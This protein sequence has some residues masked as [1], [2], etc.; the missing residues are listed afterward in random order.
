MS[1]TTKPAAPKGGLAGLLEVLGSRSLR[2]VLVLLGLWAALALHP[3]TRATFLT[4]NNFS[5]LTAQVAE[6]VIIGV[7]M[8]L[9]VLIKGIDLSVGALMAMTGVVAARLQIES[10]QPAVVAVLAAVAVGAL[11]GLWHGFL[12]TRFEI[13]PFIVTLSG[14]MAYRGVGLV[15]SGARGLSPMRDDFGALAALL[16]GPVA[17]GLCLAGAAA[18]VA[19][20]VAGERRRRALGLPTR[21]GSALLFEGAAIAGV[22]AFLLVIYQRGMPV[23]VLIAALTAVLG[24]ALLRRSRM[25][26]YAVAIGGNAEAARLS[27]VPVARVTVGIYLLT[28]VLTAIAAMVATARTN[29]VTPGNAG[30]M[31]EL[32]VISAV[33]IGGTSLNGGRAT[34]VGTI[35]G[36]LIF[37]TLSNGMNLLGVDSNWQLIF[38][39]AILLGASLLDSLSTK[40]LVVPMPVKLGLVAAAGALVLWVGRGGGSAP[41]GGQLAAQPGDAPLPKVAFI[42]STLQEE[43]YQ[44]DKRYFEEHARTLGVSAFTLAADNDNARQL[45][46]VEDALSRGAKVLVIQPTDSAA[47]AA[48]VGKARAAGAKVVAYDRSIHGGP[49]FYVAHDSHKVGVLQAEAAIKATGGKGNFVL[50]N[51]QSGHSVAIEIERG[52]MDVLRPYVERGDVKIVVQ[53]SHDSWSPEQALKTMEDAFAKTGGDIVA[54]LANNSGMARG[55]VQA[56]QAGPFKGKKVFIAGADADAANVNYVCEGKQAVEV[57][58]DIKPL[59]EKAAEVAALLARNLPVVGISAEPGKVPVVAVEVHLITPANVKPLLLDS[60]FHTAA[61]LPAC[62]K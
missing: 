43:R 27:G 31:R 44:K 15:L 61:S 62:Q 38:T 32:H 9:V 28:G 20:I 16:P 40:N 54:V 39:G 14:F 8:T 36:A 55:A 48:Y 56:V 47:A 18:G 2:M 26:R 53:K 23:P 34:M 50:L 3:E 4:A 33:V 58:K 57:L 42:L 7:G 49:D 52:Y 11:V 25:G 5:N 6:I 37:G 29:G 45:A 13:P 35:I 30:M 17:A 19:L 59:A 60:G 10:G 51:G 12:I 24:A 22:T 46:Q 1:D 41:Q 21:G